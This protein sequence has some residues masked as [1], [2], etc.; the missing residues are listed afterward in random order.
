ML[1]TEL[2]AVGHVTFGGRLAKGA[3]GFLASL[4]SK[5]MA[6]DYRDRNQVTTWAKSISAQLG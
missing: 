2:E 6:G 1:M 3:R 4:L 5:S